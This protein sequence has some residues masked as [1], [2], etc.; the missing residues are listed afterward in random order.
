MLY[1]SPSA[2]GMKRRK[3]EDAKRER[4]EAGQAS[5]VSEIEEGWQR[6]HK[7]E[8]KTENRKKEEIEKGMLIN[9]VHRLT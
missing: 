3:R 5:K 7:R 2:E 9:L 4:K 8:G 1:Q 6:I